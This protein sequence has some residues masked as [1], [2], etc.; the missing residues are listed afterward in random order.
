[1]FKIMD[2]HPT[3]RK[4]LIEAWERYMNDTYTRDDLALVLDSIKDDEHIQ[5][6]R[7]VFYRKLDMAMND[8]LPTPEERKEIYRK[9]FAQ[10]LAEYQT[11][12]AKQTIHPPSRNIIVR[13]R[14][15]WY[16][17]AAVILF[18]LL[19]PAAYLYLNPK[20]EQISVQYVELATQ[21]GE[22]KTVVLPDQTAVTLNVGSR[23]KYPANFSGDERS[24][25][26]AGEALFNVTS[27]PA[28]PF[29]VI[30]ENMNIKVVGT[31][32]DVKEY[33]D[34]LTASVSVASG[35]VEVS[36]AGE[37]LML[38]K[39][40]QV[41]MDRATGKFEKLSIDADNYLSWTNGT[42][43]FYRTPIREVVNILNR[44]YSQVNFEL[45]EGDYYNVISGE[46]DNISP[47]AML[48]SIVRTTG[49]KCEK[50]GENRYTLYK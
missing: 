3:I 4:D 45:A 2:N 42:L 15:I 28:R 35:K 38:A 31:V 13:F 29:I 48:N 14:K 37:K 9:K 25:E 11:K 39:N 6:F 27:D 34:D 24:V 46:H 18:G 22:I 32:F 36:L 40:Y 5:E 50:T 43:F 16:A 17:A 49:L 1:M 47:E 7:E 19:I 23:I 8:L 41:K 21:R 20:T 10:L 44:H 26:L 12:K 30:T 33:A